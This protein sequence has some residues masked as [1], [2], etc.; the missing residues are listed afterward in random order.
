M[1]GLA[2][3]TATVSYAADGPNPDGRLGEN[4]VMDDV[5][6]GF[7]EVVVTDGRRRHT[8]EL[9]VFAGRVNWVEIAVP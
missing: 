4:F 8:A 7:Y 1:D 9:W 3:Y 2:P 6:P 5:E